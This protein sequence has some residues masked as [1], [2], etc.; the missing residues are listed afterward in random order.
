MSLV[1]REYDLPVGDLTLFKPDTVYGYARI[2][3][4]NK[5]LYSCREITKGP[6]KGKFECVY[7]K[8]PKKY[9]SVRLAKKEIR[10]LET[11]WTRK[12]KSKLVRRDQ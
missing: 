6:D 7:L 5:P 2:K 9:A 12:K 3:G 11:P 10:I 4:I 1:K 8:K